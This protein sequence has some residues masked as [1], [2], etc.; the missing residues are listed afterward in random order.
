VHRFRCHTFPYY[1]YYHRTIESIRVVAI[2]HQHRRLT[3]WK[4]RLR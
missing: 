3:M 4:V 2:G 1:V